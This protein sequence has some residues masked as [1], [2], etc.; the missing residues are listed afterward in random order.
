M[1]EGILLLLANGNICFKIPNKLALVA[2]IQTMVICMIMKCD[3][4]MH[5]AVVADISIHQHLSCG[6]SSWQLHGGRQLKMENAL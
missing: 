1:D 5:S 4:V 3:I 2:E 6:S